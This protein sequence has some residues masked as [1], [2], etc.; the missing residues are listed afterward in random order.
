MKKKEKNKKVGRV[1]V[2]VGWGRILNRKER[3]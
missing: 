3:I 1:M 2:V